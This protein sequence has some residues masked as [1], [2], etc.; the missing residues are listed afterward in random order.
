M[1][2][3]KITCIALIIQRNS[4]VEEFSLQIVDVGFIERTLKFLGIKSI[5]D[6]NLSNNIAAIFQ[7]C[8]YV[9]HGYLDE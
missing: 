5:K 7:G 9:L 8:V 6:R 4:E 2:K 1:P 3:N